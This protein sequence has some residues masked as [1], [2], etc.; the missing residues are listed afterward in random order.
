MEDQCD[1]RRPC[2]LCVRA[3]VPCVPSRKIGATEKDVAV[4]TQASFSLDQIR[5]RDE[6]KA[7]LPEQSIL[8]LSTKVRFLLGFLAHSKIIEIGRL[9]LVIIRPTTLQRCQEERK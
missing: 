3:G 2:Q 6:E 4:G 1:R 7:V 8:E 9:F 5:P